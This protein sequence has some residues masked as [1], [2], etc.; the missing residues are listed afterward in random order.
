MFL[1]YFY[2]NKSFSCI[3][4]IMLVKN[5]NAKNEKTTTLPTVNHWLKY[6]ITGKS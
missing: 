1:M 2:C 5:K 4:N 6:M 3:L